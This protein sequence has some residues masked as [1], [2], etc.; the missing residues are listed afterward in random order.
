M[1]EQLVVTKKRYLTVLCSVV[2]VGMLVLCALIYLV[3][4]NQNLQT[5]VTNQLENIEKL[6]KEKEENPTEELKKQLHD[7]E[8]RIIAL[9]G[10]R[11]SLKVTVER[12]RKENAEK[13]K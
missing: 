1:R 3:N 8:T 4:E 7:A 5:Q 6:E 11:D 10:E 12:L 13:T 9:E 2:I